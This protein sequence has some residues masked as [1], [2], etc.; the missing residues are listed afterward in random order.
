[1]QSD[2][3]EAITGAITGIRRAR[4]WSTVPGR[5]RMLPGRQPHRAGAGRPYRAGQRAQLVPG[6]QVPCQAKSG[7]VTVDL[8][9]RELP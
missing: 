4:A 3:T 8:G 6:Q 5:R 7:Q 9:D 1:M 2:T